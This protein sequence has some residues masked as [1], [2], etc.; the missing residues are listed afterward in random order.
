MLQASRLK[1]DSIP[2]SNGVITVSIANGHDTRNSQDFPTNGHSTHSHHKDISVSNSR[3]FAEHST[4]ALKKVKKGIYISY[5]PDAGFGERAF[6]SDMVRQLK[7]NNMAD[8]IWFDKDENCIDSPIWFSQRMEAAEKCQ[9]AILVLSD[10]YFTCPVSVYEARTLMERRL[11]HPNS[12]KTYSIL[13][14]KLAETDISKNY[15][16]LLMDAVDLTT[17]ANCKLSVAEKTSVVLSSIMET[18]EKF[19]VINTPL[20]VVDDVEPQ[21]NGEYKSKVFVL[22]FFVSLFTKYNNFVSF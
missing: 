2:E 14:S 22:L 16:S 3:H 13:Y 8:D 9:A 17:S 11:S 19:A 4:V 1:M 7:E 15:S 18:L 12:V 21:F 6:V 5:S 10:Q 20:K